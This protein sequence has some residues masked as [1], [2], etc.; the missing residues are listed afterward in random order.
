VQLRNRIETC[1]Q[2]LTAADHRLVRLLLADPARAAFQSIT[3]LAADAG[4]HVSSAVRLAQKL[5]F[6]GYPELR[7]QLQAE[8]LSA[9]GPADRMRRTVARAPS[10][11]ILEALVFEERRT[12]TALLDHVSDARLAEAADVLVGAERVAVFGHGH[13]AALAAIARLRFRRAGWRVADLSV[14]GRDLAEEAVLLGPRD[15][16]LAFALRRL[17][18]G[19]A[20]LLETAH[21]AGARSVLVSDQLGVMVR[22]QPTVALVAPRG[23]DDRYQTLTVPMTV[24]NALVLEVAARDGGRTIAGLERLARAAERFETAEQWPAQ[25]PPRLRRGARPA[26]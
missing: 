6:K 1:P 22:P 11:S 12:L 7:A 25:P 5:G 24:L 9:G 2:P 10:G 14:R 26:G 4:V 16:V 15:V 17:P 13:A 23:A 8:V 3:E 20:P 18:Q 21:E 19:L